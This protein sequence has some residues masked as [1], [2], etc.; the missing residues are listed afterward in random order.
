MV[1]V[2]LKILGAIEAVVGGEYGIFCLAQ[3]R[4]HCGGLPE[5]VA[6]LGT[7]CVGIQA[8]IKSATRRAHFGHQPVSGAAGHLGVPLIARCTG[9]LGINAQ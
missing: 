7:R 5:V 3:R 4:T 9:G 2:S 1:R 8:G 6:A